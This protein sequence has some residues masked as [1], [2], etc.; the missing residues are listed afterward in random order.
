MFKEKLSEDLKE[1]MRAKD[2]ARLRTI[3][4]LRAALLEKEIEER[5]GGEARL[6]EAQ[7]LAVLQKQAK[8]RRDAIAQFDAAGRA[9]LVAI[10]QEELDLIEAYLPEQLDEAAIRRV[11]QEVIQA[12][13]AA[14]MRDMGKVMGQSIA[15]LKGR[16]DGKRVNAI[17]RELL[18]GGE[19]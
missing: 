5:K 1:A 4:L 15:R 3:R 18:A 7:E 10:E 11:V 13:G 12:T 17:A 16:A 9:D 8:Q 14:S 2:A 19:A 6:T